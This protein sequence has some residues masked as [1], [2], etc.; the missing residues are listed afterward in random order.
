MYLSFMLKYHIDRI[1]DEEENNGIEQ[2]KS[3]TGKKNPSF[4][5]VQIY[6]IPSKLSK[7]TIE[8]RIVLM[9]FLYIQY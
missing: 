1:P 6:C 3:K 9:K 8:M 4:L 5:A 7:D 2:K